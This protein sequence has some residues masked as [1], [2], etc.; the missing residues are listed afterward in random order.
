M[1]T[2]R[3]LYA[4]FSSPST[5]P[6][7]WRPTRAS[8]RSTCPCAPT[9]TTAACDACTTR[10]VDGTNRPRPANPTNPGK[11]T[12]NVANHVRVPYRCDCLF[13]DSCRT[14]P[15]RR[16]ACARARWST[17]GW[18]W[19]LARACIS[20][21][22]LKCRKCSKCIRSLGTI[23][24]RR[25]DATWFRSGTQKK[26]EQILI[27]LLVIHGLVVRNQFFIRHEFYWPSDLLAFIFSH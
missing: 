12:N 15:T 7:T 3:W 17:R 6:C 18:P 25:K 23:T 11:S 21:V 24:A 10:T 1:Y 2:C 16:G 9:G 4:F 19:R 5:R 22:S 20:V 26:N 27:L 13:T 8:D 14:W